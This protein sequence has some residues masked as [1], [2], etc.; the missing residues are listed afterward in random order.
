MEKRGG[1][2]SPKTTENCSFVFSSFCW[3]GG[4]ERESP[5]LCV[6]A[7]QFKEFLE[8]MSPTW[9]NLFQSFSTDARHTG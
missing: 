6:L 8:I 3:G 9:R 2:N 5:H 1:V 4:E 7:K